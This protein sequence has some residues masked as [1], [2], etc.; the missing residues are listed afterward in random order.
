MFLCKTAKKDTVEARVKSVQVGTAHVTNAR[1][2]LAFPGLGGAA[3]H[4]ALVD[5]SQVLLPVL[6]LKAVHMGAAGRTHDRRHMNSRGWG[7]AG[8][9]E[10]GREFQQSRMGRGALAVTAQ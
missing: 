1:L 5:D 4:E 6:H 3:P 9:E 7:G 8:G 10:P 2:S